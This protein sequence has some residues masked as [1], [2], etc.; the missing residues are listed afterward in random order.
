MQEIFRVTVHHISPLI[1]ST[2]CHKQTIS[3]RQDF[4]Q[5]VTY[6]NERLMHDLKF[7][8]CY[9]GCIVSLF[10]DKMTIIPNGSQISA[11]LVYKRFWAVLVWPHTFIFC[12]NK[13][14]SVDLH[15]FFRGGVVEEVV[16]RSFLCIFFIYLNGPP[17]ACG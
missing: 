4:K 14:F 12:V 3:L 7:S 15:V 2:D 17:L 8:M 13:W 1:Y 9:N 16:Y 5:Q 10:C 11:C 6:K